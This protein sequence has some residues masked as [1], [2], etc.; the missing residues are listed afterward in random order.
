V[1]V[2]R[3]GGQVLEHGQLALEAE[4]AALV[5]AVLLDL[6][7]VGVDDHH[8]ARAVDDHRVPA[9]DQ[10]GQVPESDDGGDAHRAGD[11]RGVARAPADVGGEPAHVRLV[12]R[13]GLAGQQVVRDHD[14]VAVQVL[15]V[16]ALLADQA[17][18]HRLL[19]VVD[20]RH[21]A[22]EVAVGHR[23]ELV[24]QAAHDDA[25]GVLGGRVLVADLVEHLLEDRL[26]AQQPEVEVE[27]AADLASVLGGDLVAE[28]RALD[29]GVGDRVP[30]P[31]ALLAELRALD[32]AL[33]DDQ[34][35]GVEYDGRADH[36][37]GGNAD[38]F[39]DLHRVDFPIADCRLPI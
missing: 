6:L 22:G 16:R 27:D 32:R 8:P 24:G 18:Q 15:E 37:P 3:L 31:L 4:L 20:V 12:Q 30:E 36:H 25:D 14:H 7:L 17:A 2:P 10:T 21:A 1:P 11:D 23:D 38:A 29:D 19:D 35:L 26:V 13:R 33:G 9:A 39:L 5:L 34:V 28:L